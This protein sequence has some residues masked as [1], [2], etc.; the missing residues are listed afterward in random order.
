MIVSLVILTAITIGAIVTMERSSG[1]LRMISNM[2]TQQQVFKTAHSPL[3]SIR[4]SM[5]DTTN[6]NK[7]MNPL[8][9]LARAEEQQG[10]SYEDIKKI[11]IDPTSDQNGSKLIK[12]TSNN[13]GITINSN[14]LHITHLPGN[15]GGLK[16]SDGNSALI[17][18]GELRFAN[19]TSA[20][21]SRLNSTQM[22]EYRRLYLLTSQDN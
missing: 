14:A 7:A 19:I 4:R 18:N 20:S 21:T 3:T 13:K 15:D 11:T 2:Q 17:A 10:K 8:V 6:F 5:R 16:N 22:M 12:Q 9:T 1:Q